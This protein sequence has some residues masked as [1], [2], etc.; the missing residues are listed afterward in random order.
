MLYLLA[1]EKGF[2]PLCL[3]GKRF[4]RP[5]RY[6][7]F[8]TP[9]YRVFIITLF[10]ENVNVFA[11]GCLNVLKLDHKKQV[12]S[13][14]C[15]FLFR[16]CQHLFDEDAVAAGGVVDEDMGDRADEFAVLENGRAAHPLHNAAGL[17]QQALVGDLNTKV[18]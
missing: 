1:E 6:D 16:R 9:P 15:F 11:I 4:S 13:K 3:L 7:H 2:E 14:T 12:L 17:F 5:P 8:D 10:F 18:F